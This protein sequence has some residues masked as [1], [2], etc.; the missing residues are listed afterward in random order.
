MIHKGSLCSDKHV[1]KC[2]H[3]SAKFQL[4]YLLSSVQKIWCLRVGFGF[5]RVGS[6][7]IKDQPSANQ[8]GPTMVHKWQWYTH[9]LHSGS[10]SW[11]WRCKEHPCPLSPDLGL[12]R[13]LEVPD[14]GFWSWSWFM[15]VPYAQTNMSWSFHLPQSSFSSDICSAQPRKYDV[16][17]CQRGG[18]V[19]EFS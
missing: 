19:V 13:T 14:W 18:W 6:A 2:S 15:K 3:A 17:G 10:L 5:G 16:S 12:W 4:S 11:F 7:K 9:V 8:N 1:L